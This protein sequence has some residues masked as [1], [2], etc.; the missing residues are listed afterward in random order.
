MATVLLKL[1]NRVKTGHKIVYLQFQK[2]SSMK[3]TV[4]LQN[5]FFDAPQ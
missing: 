1:A 3:K 5:I 2:R 4:K